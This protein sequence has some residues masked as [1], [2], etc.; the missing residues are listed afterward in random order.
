[1]HVLATVGSGVSYSSR[2][3]R[4]GVLPKFKVKHDCLALQTDSVILL[5]DT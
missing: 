5:S 3:H 1:M 2:W 4:N